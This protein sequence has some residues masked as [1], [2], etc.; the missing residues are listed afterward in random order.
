MNNTLLSDL[1]AAHHTE[2]LRESARRRLAREALRTR[3]GGLALWTRTRLRPAR[4][5]A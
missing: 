5:A 4:R 2:V 3:S 1:V